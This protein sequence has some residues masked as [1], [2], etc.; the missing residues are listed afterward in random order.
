MKKKILPLKKIK[1]NLL[2]SKNKKIVLC[3]GVF[4]LLHIGHIRHFNE[5]KKKGDILIV[6]ITP[7]KYVKKGPNRPVFPSHIRMEAISELD[8]VDYVFAN[9]TPTAINP[10]SIFKPHFYCK[11]VEYKDYSNDL[12][13]E[14]KNEVKCLKKY[15]GKIVYTGGDVYSSSSIINKT[16]IN[17]NKEQIDFLNKIKNKKTYRKVKKIPEIFKSFENL[18]ILVIGETIIDEYNFCEA[19][20]KSGKEPVLVLR[21][22]YKE[23]Y[24]GGTA[25]IAKNLTSFSNNIT[26]ISALGEKNEEASFVN[27]NLGKNVKSFFLKKK[28]SPTIVKKRFVE[29]VNKTKVLG[30]YSINDQS[31]YKTEE[32]KFNNWLRKEIPKNDLVIVSDYGHGLISNNSAKLIL[33]KSKF[34]AVNTQLNASNAGYHVIS[35]YKGA[36]MAII[37]ETELRQEL[38]NKIDGVDILIKQISK[39]ISSSFSI[40]TCGKLGSK[41]YDRLNK[42]IIS[43]PAF[44]TQVTDK[45]GTG[46]TMLAL[47][48]IAIFKKLDLRFCMLLSSIAAAYNISYM[49]NSTPLSRGLIT[50]AV[51]SYLK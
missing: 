48:S 10:I 29:D 1:K 49:A 12:T 14:I 4:D 18:K 27:K 34:L 37:N 11:G 38:R 26:L 23:K 5:A 28:N 22:L 40:V 13:G 50:K 44:A 51:Q 2:K 25:A 31:L 19:L 24:L 20:G 21:D 6:S 8:C 47:L 42:K 33:K 7:D 30:V 41:I 39:K 15:G 36:D 32:Y 43:C 3:H 17:L 45:I 46:D 9:T 16:D 35:K